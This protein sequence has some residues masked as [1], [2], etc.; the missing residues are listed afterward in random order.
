MDTKGYSKAIIEEIE[1]LEIMD[2]WRKRALEA[3]SGIRTR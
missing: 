2:T 3:A 1:A